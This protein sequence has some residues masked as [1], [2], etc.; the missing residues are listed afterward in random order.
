MF[1]RKRLK[2]YRQALEAV[3]SARFG[4]LVL[5]A[6]EW[7][8][9]GPWST[10][11]DELVRARREFPV[12]IYAAGQLSQRRKK[13]RRLGAR[14]KT[15]DPEQLHR[16][17]IQVKKA[18]YS[19][20]FFSGLFNGK[21]CA[22]RCKTITSSLMKL[23]NSLGTINDIVTHKTLFADIIARRTRGLTD[24]QNHHRAYAA[25]LIIGSQQAQVQRSFDRAHKAY[26]R[27][28][29]AKA[30]WKFTD[31]KRPSGGTFG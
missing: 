18:R 23:Q 8:E 26:S 4:R 7:V 19:I 5:D 3:R 28:D 25:G 24:E 15:L 2:S 14:I 1:A 20:E 22:K 11:E 17:R 9:T 13:I 27:F 30:F 21:E 10:S 12:E 31:P 29:R 16:L 6:V